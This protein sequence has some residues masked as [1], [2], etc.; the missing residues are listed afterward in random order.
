MRPEAYH[1]LAAREDSYWWY[2]A[3]RRLALALLRRHGVKAGARTIDLGCGCGSN[4]ALLETL[5]ASIVLGLDLS[6]IALEF[7]RRKAPDA[8]LVRADLSRS[9]PFCAASFD[10]A[11]LFNVLYHDWVTDDRAVLERIGELLRPGGLLLI[12]EAAF[13]MLRRRLDRAVMGRRRYRL[14]DLADL[15]EA[16]E[17]DVLFASYVLS[18]AFP[19][20][21]VAA[22]ID[23]VSWLRK[24]EQNSD[25]ASLEFSPL[26]A[27]LDR[28]AFALASRE[29]DALAAGWKI[30][31]GVGLVAVLRRRG[32][33]S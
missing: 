5:G 17:F 16:G 28:V 8:D 7:A 14:S 30:P 33:D 23:R 21:F 13:T 1:R 2:R 11:T 27:G 18:F 29:A 25:L 12:T 4:L 22:L 31:F 6:P 19:L 9:L 24:H 26:A 20:A 32:G 10:V 3:R 15:A